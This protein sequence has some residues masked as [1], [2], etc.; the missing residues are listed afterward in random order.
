MS[1]KGSFIVI[2]ILALV[3]AGYLQRYLGW[4][5]PWASLPNDNPPP[6]TEASAPPTTNTTSGQWIYK[7][8]VSTTTQGYRWVTLYFTDP[9]TIFLVPVSRQIAKSPYLV[10][11]TLDQLFAGPNPATG[12]QPSVLAMQIR[13]LA[14]KGDTVRVDFPESQAVATST[15][16]STGGTLALNAIVATLTGIPG[17]DQVQFL[18]NGHTTNYM[19]HDQDVSAPVPGPKWISDKNQLTLYYALPVNGRAFLVP[20]QIS[21]QESQ[22]NTAAAADLNSLMA[23]AI[24][25]L[26][27]KRTVGEFSL[28]PALPAE[29]SLVD[30]S[31]KGDTA[32]LN[33]SPSLLTALKDDPNRE[34]LM[35]DAIVFTATAFPDVTKV[36][37]L[38]DGQ[39]PNA[40]LGVMPLAQPQSRPAWI[41]PE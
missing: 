17:I 41:N 39:K 13:G 26:K 6:G 1:R 35:A 2:L 32:Y 40:S 18:V 23:R 7:P 9:N 27:T 15:W 29:V 33:F 5:M 34:A 21:T 36:Q 24:N 11:D 3:A 25:E 16:G 14:V 20:F 37:F 8:A 30:A 38:V 31:V 12:L 10:K 22:N 28:E 4:Q 19:F